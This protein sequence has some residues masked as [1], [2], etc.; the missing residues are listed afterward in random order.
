[1]EKIRDLFSPEK[2][3]LKVR[4][5]KSKGIYIEDATECYVSEEN[6]VFELMKLGNS[7]RA[8]SATNMNEGSSR[9]HM[10]FMMS[11]HQNN[12]HEMSAK[13]GKLYLVDLAGSEK[14]GKTGASGSL[15]EEAK[16][17][18]KS[19]SALGNVINALTDAKGQQHIPYRDS[20]L[21]RVLQESLGGNART[22]L[23]ITCSPS[24]FNDAETLS[25]LRFGYRAKSIKN[26]PKINREF[27]VAELQMLLERAEKTIE[28]KEKR[29]K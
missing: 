8:I 28:E 1:M 21:T 23:I 6:D 27:T 11:I 24:P 12:L 20:K 26:K 16:M 13:T 2:T 4:E 15:L 29:I 7:H 5:D 25:T 19:L 9:S 3:N 17:I 14:V 22:T 10:L 18:N